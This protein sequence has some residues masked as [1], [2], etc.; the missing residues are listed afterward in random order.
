MCHFKRYTVPCV[1]Y[2]IEQIENKNDKEYWY[3]AVTVWTFWDW[4]IA[5]LYDIQLNP[6]LADAMA[7]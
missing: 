1:T 3:S 4:K 5:L 6:V 7:P 2:D